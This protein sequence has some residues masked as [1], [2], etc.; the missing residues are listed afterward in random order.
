M[1]NRM[2]LHIVGIQDLCF[3][4]NLDFQLV[5]SFYWEDLSQLWGFPAGSVV[6]NPPD[7]TRDVG[8]IP[9]SGRSPGERNSNPLQYSCWEIPW[10]EV[11]G[12]LHSLG[13]Q[14]SH[15]PLCD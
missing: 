3:K 14:K 12:G 11:P 4:I 6:K 8:F 1:L 15:T 9:E 13:S 10:T 5:F 2:F 7:N